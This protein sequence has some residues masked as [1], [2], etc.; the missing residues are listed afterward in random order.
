MN[1]PRK[2]A[3]WLFVVVISG[4]P[5]TSSIV[6]T[7]IIIE[8]K[9]SY[10]SI[11]LCRKKCG[12]M[13]ITCSLG[14]RLEELPRNAGTVVCRAVLQ[15]TQVWRSSGPCLCHGREIYRASGTCFSR[16]P[17]LG[18]QRNLT[19]AAGSPVCKEIR[20]VYMKREG[21]KFVSW[22]HL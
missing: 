3:L 18:T 14:I 9:E 5:K 16:M 8:V 22:I 20:K 6:R 11:T 10:I 12:S 2:L 17:I 13:E 7:N 1:A 4:D 19:I 15:R 21:D